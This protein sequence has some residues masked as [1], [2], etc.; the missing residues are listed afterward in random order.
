MGTIDIGIGHDD[1]LLIAQIINIEFCANPDAERFAKVT[2]LSIRA[3][4]IRG[5]AQDVENF[6]LE[7]QKCLVDAITRAFA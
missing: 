6:S 4:F 3:E 2:D 5:G 7:R 1:D